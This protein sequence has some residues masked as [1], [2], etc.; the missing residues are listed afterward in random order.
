MMRFPVLPAVV[1]IAIVAPGASRAD[2]EVVYNHVSGAPLSSVDR[3]SHERLS[4]RYKMIDFTDQDHSWTFP[5]GINFE[6]VPRVYKDGVCVEG[7]A[8]IAYVIHADGS[9]SDAFAF[10]TS[11]SFLEAMGVHL[12]EERHFTPGRLDGHPVSSIAWSRFRFTCPPEPK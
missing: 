8:N 1:S 3:I 5:H 10:Q 9:V 12:A 2:S 4:K 7:V 11:N 6:P